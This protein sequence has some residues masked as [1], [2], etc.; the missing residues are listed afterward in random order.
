LVPL[1]VEKTNAL[2]EIRETSIKPC[3][4]RMESS[5]VKSGESQTKGERDA[6]CL[7]GVRREGVPRGKGIGWQKVTTGE[8][9]PQTIEN[10]G[11]WETK[12]SW[13]IWKRTGG[14]LARTFLEGKYIKAGG[15]KRVSS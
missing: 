14:K 8:T 4:K 3:E 10:K 2:G 13:D 15:G 7:E 11:V 9:H 1:P 12:G 5:R 6:K